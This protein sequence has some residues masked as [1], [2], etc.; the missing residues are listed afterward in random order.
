M[1][2]L[3]FFLSITCCSCSLINSAPQNFDKPKLNISIDES[4][5]LNQVE[6]KVLTKDNS[7]EYFAKN[8]AAFALTEQQYKNLSLN[9][10]ELKYYIRKQLKIIRLYKDYYEASSTDDE[11]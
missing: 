4:I 3:L 10:E 11:K 8:D 7:I 2:P 1:K 9:I 6:F 5:N